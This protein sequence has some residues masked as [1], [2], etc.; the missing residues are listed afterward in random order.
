MKLKG[1]WWPQITY[2]FISLCNQIISRLTVH[3]FES[4]IE[5]YKPGTQQLKNIEAYKI[6]INEQ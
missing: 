4:F 2:V 5:F 1:A 6:T 3:L